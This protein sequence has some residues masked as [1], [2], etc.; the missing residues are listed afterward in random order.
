MRMLP[1]DYAVRNLGRSRVRLALS[2]VGSTLVVLLAIA[3]AGFVRGMSK[4]LSISGGE[5]NVMLLGAGSEESVERSEIQPSVPGL[6]AASV[7]GIR[8]R[9]GVAFVSPEV[10]MQTTVMMERGQTGNLQI[11]VRGVKET[12]YLVHSQVSVVEGRAPLPGRDEILVGRL[13]AQKLGVEPER[14]KM[15]RTIYFDDRAWTVAGTFAAPGSVMESEI[16]CPLT[17]LQIAAKRDNLSCVVVTLE[18]GAEFDDVDAF[19]KQRLDLEMVA[20]RESDYYGKL[21]AFFAPIRAMVWVTAILIAS[22]G[23]LGGLN[24]MYAA[25]ASRVREVGALQVVGFSRRAIVASLMQES[26]LAAAAG[27]VLAAVAALVLLD[28]VTVQFSAGVFGLVVDAPVVGLGLMAGLLLGIVGSL[29]AAFR[30]LRLPI[31]E[32]L[33]AN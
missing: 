4:S 3:A 11:M 16:W 13:A 21:A 19:V 9:L 14:L 32:A 2:L 7:A 8:Q 6:V 25:F 23:I 24:T 29:P 33:K 5:R 17:D 1:V 10:Q 27:T 20:M 28:G 30:C 22:G 31:P 15:G 18:D 26:L 12:A